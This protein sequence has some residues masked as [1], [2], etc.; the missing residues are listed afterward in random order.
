MLD[1]IGSDRN[2][3]VTLKALETIGLLLAISGI[4]VMLIAW[5]GFLLW[6]GIQGAMALVHWL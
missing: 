3:R 2:R 4:M 1:R 5:S 6:L